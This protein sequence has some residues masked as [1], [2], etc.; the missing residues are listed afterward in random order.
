MTKSYVARL[1]A[2]GVEEFKRQIMGAAD[3]GTAAWDALVKKVPELGDASERTAARVTAANKRL[4]E[5]ARREFLNLQASV[6]P[7]AASMARLAT[8]SETAMRAVKAGVATQEEADAALNRLATSSGFAVSGLSRLEVSL[9]RASGVAQAAGIPTGAL[10]SILSVL[11]TTAGGP[12]VLGLTAAAV[13]T[14]L[15]VGRVVE[16]D[17]AITGLN[18]NLARHG[19]SLA[20]TKTG[21]QTLANEVARLA[22]VSFGDAGGFIEKTLGLADADQM[23]R[24]AADAQAL[25]LSLEDLAR[26]AQSPAESIKQLNEKYHALSDFQA[27]QLMPN[28]EGLISLLDKTA[29]QFRNAG[30]ETKTW[31]EWFAKLG[32]AIEQADSG[33]AAFGAKAQ[34]FNAPFA[35]PNT[36]GFMPTPF[37][38]DIANL[39]AAGTEAMRQKIMQEKQGWV[40]AAKEFNLQQGMAQREIDAANAAATE[41]MREKIL[42]EKKA[43]ADS[44]LEFIREQGEEQR[45]IDNENAAGTEAMREKLHREKLDDAKD[46]AAFEQEVAQRSA[47][48]LRQG[49]DSLFQFLDHVGGGNNAQFS[50]LGRNVLDVLSPKDGSKSILSGVNL[51]PTLNGLF[52]GAGSLAASASP[53]MAA[54]QA[55]MQI[56]SI[57]TP[58]LSHVFGGRPNDISN[59][60]GTFLGPVPGA[61][62]SLFGPPP[63]NYTAVAN[64][65]GGFTG[66]SLSGDKP[67]SNTSGLA[68]QAGSAVEQAVAQLKGYGLGFSRGLDYLAIGQRDSSYFRL[69]GGSNTNTGTVGDP[70][71]LAFKAVKALLGSASGGSASLT[72]A[73][74]GA[75]SLNDVM[76]RA[77]F[78]TQTYDVITKGGPAATDFETAMKALVQSFTD[79]SDKARQFGLDVSAFTAG[80]AESFDQNVRLQLLSI[81]QPMQ[82]AIELWKRDAV[83][84]LQAAQAIGGDIAQV[85]KL[86]AA[87]YSQMNAGPISTLTGLQSS[88]GYGQFSAAAPDAQ[89]FGALT[90]YN[91]AKNSAL[92]GG[93]P[94][95]YASAASNLLNI[96]RNYL[97]TSTAYGDLSRDVSGTISALVDRLST[98]PGVDVP[99]IVNATNNQTAVLADRLDQTNQRLDAMAEEQRDTNRR[100]TAILLRAK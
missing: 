28:L 40:D 43:D 10:S 16:Y 70:N 33:I 91:K 31:A 19:N 73:L 2:E 34:G 90:D 58:W 49:F 64:F 59:T 21:V 67:N 68:G 79:G 80:F 53:Y 86:N 27:S 65:G 88:I 89:Y 100:M 22:N 23:K 76:T 47:A 60:I 29:E 71:D 20:L 78:V 15:V 11:G 42:Q 51:G 74:G 9:L 63:S 44:A 41:A 26:M 55:V 50:L 24:L 82:S 81:E 8:A 3:G 69:T 52:S 32:A 95:A 83:A 96:G 54:A 99:A 45:R 61:I 38:I 5:E 72:T 77:Q 7:A 6:D 94:N 4:V 48:K 37:D 66:T 36:R 84:R 93:D 35:G 18:Q 13:A 62:A 14:A 92:N 1:T 85:Q 12:V 30:G 56:N 46:L 17:N 39:N 87:L 98:P 75:T 97:G 25:G 57:T